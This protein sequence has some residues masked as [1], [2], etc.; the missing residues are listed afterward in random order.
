MDILTLMF[1]ELHLKR[2]I[3]MQANFRAPWSIHIP[4]ESFA[5]FHFVH[6]GEC[7]LCFDE[8]GF[9]RLKEGDLV[10]FPKG[11]ART[12]CSSPDESPRLMYDMLPPLT[13]ETVY[14]PLEHGGSGALTRL[15]GGGLFLE[16]AEDNH[17]LKALP[18][19]I[20]LRADEVP[21]NDWLTSHMRCLFEEGSANRLGQDLLIS[22]LSEVLFLHA[23][24][25]YVERLPEQS[26]GFLRALQEPR[27]LPIL[28]ALHHQ[29]GK[30][31]SVASMARKAKM[32]R[33]SFARLFPQL[34]GQTPMRYLIGVRMQKAARLLKQ[35]RDSVLTIALEVGYQSQPSFSMAFRQHFGLSPRDFRKQKRVL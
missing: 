17:I 22:R 28:Q 5:S 33:A 29:P 18:K 14:F 24:R 7:F 12:L 34:L 32:S 8:Q 21:S 35:T 4:Q 30:E 10:L 16:N 3:H 15:W 27:L 2:S 13:P 26:D 6:S 11:A 19:A 25:T 9:L 20:L 31:W 23:I 1:Q